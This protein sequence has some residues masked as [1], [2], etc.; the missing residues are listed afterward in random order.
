M[1]E[2]ITLCKWAALGYE[3][4]V[5]ELFFFCALTVSSHSWLASC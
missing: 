3:I 4:L 1:L 5:S 2:L